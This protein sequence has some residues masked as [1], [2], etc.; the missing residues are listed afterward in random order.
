[1]KK[2]IYSILIHLLRV[3]AGIKIRQVKPLIIGVTGSIGKTSCLH[4]LDAVIKTHYS[5]RT[6]FKAN[7]EAGLPLGI[8]GIRDKLSGFGVG[9]WLSAFLAIPGALLRRESFQVLI[10]EM[11][12]DSPF[13]P[14]NMGYLLKIVQPK[15]GLLLNI[16]PVH[17]Q[18]FAAA[19]PND[20]K[21]DVGALLSLIATEKGKLLISLPK[22]GTAIVNGDDERVVRI[23]PEIRA[24]VISVGEG[25]KNQV[26]LTGYSITQ[27]GSTFT[28]RYNKN[29]YTITFPD[30]LLFKEFGVTVGFVLAVA[31]TLNIPLKEAITAIE[32]DYHEPAGRLTVITGKNSTTIIDSSY[33]SSPEALRVTLTLLS[34]LKTKGKKILVLGDMRELG[35]LA[36]SEHK[37]AASQ[38]K[39]VGD[40]IVLVGPLMTKYTA[41]ELVKTGHPKDKLLVFKT[42]E[43]VG[44][45]L[46]PL[47]ESGDIMLVKGSQ[48]TVFLETIVKEV[49]AEP[50]KAKDLLCRQGKM[51]DE[52]REKYFSSHPNERVLP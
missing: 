2:V 14:Q 52:I 31:Q 6:T 47:L 16:A 34:E 13:E 46:L 45:K 39:T 49:M 26:K 7:S 20:Q 28:Y 50:E 25:S 22:N 19:L 41:P 3:A 27:K 12:V 5:V 33:N 32:A 48:N 37:K 38:I 10:A 24:E 40:L 8:L 44:E 36:E 15:I 11:G 9:G 35:E 4:L 29:D 51:W 18:Q 42:S 23:V 1:M 21:N 30:K 43:G 17:T